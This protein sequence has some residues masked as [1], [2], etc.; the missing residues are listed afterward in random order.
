LPSLIELR[1]ISKNFGA[2]QALKDVSLSLEA[3][4]ILALV[5]ENGAGKSTLM[6]VLSGVYA[7]GDYSGLILQNH[8]EIRF[9]SPK[10][11]EAAGIALIHQELSNFPHLTVAE[12]MVVGHWPHQAGWLQTEKIVQF[13]R[14]WLDKLGADFSVDQ[15]MAE[16]STG[17]QQVV[18]IAKALSKNSKVLILDEP[19]SSLT[20]RETQKLFQI[21]RTLK[22][23][24]CGLIYISHRMEEI[25]ALADRV[26]ILRDGKSVFES[27][28]RGLTEAQ[29]V[30]HMVGRSLD[31]MFPPRLAPPTNDIILEVRNFK[32]KHR[33]SEISRG[34]LSFHLNRGE[35]LGFSGLLGAGRSEILQALA[36]DRAYETSGEV[37]F[38]G[39]KIL[40]KNLQSSFKQGLGLVPEDRK[41]Q[42]LLPTRSLNEN[43]GVLRLS[44]QTLLSWI[45]PA[46]EIER[47]QRDLKLLKTRFHHPEQKITELSGGNQQKVIFSRVLQNTPDVLILDEPTRG[48][49]VGA[50][51]E[52]Y[53][54]IRELTHQG[55]SILLVSSDLP[56]LMALSDRVLVM[57]QGKLSQELGPEN[58]HEEVIMKWA[59]ENE[60][61]NEVISS[62]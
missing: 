31:Q 24:G 40:W 50:K 20:S 29:I 7:A 54:L 1:G 3:G 5:G 22:T 58:I 60:R 47:T 13:A 36:G 17:Q 6:K 2:V 30:Q 8:Q 53:Q 48:V 18:E 19:T 61:K 33:E 32:A 27:P 52:I 41:I 45:K 35:I 49:D 56:E 38:K 46:R 9:Q 14:S 62:P 28:L 11:S 16:L 59:L 26:S 10:D 4:E 44:Q 34:P 15:K 39:S 55:K 51:Y 57:S 23:Q 37:R 21:L 42:S 25:F 43:A 12:N